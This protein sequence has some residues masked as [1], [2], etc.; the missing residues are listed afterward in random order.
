MADDFLGDRR[1]A[2]EESFFAKENARLV[3]QMKSEAKGRASA[4]GLAEITGLTDEAVLDKLVALGIEVDTWAAISLV[5]LVEV[6]WANGMVEAKERAAVLTAAEANGIVPGSPSHE[7][8]DRWLERRPDGRLLEAWQ[9]YIVD[10][11]TS[12]SDGEKDAVKRKVIGR[13]RE[14]AEATGGFLGLGSKVSAEEEVVLA[15]LAKAFG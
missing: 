4:A 10:L 1:K 5:P 13:A 9:E 6:A 8:L 12:L 14:V 11:C 2:L 3:D 7:L 15:Q